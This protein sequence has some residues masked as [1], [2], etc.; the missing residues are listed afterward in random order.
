MSRKFAH[1]VKFDSSSDL[2]ESLIKSEKHNLK[3]GVVVK[4][5][6]TKIE[7]DTIVVDIGYKTE[8]RIPA[9]EFKLIIGAVIPN[10]GDTV[11]VYIERLEGRGGK[12]IL[13]RQKA[14]REEAWKCLEDSYAKG[15][16][17]DGVIFSRVKGG[18]AVDLSGVVG[19]LPGGQVDIRPIKDPTPLMNIVQ[20]FRILKMDSVQGNIVIS[21]RAVIED[22]RAEEKEK[23]LSTVQEGMILDGFV[24]NITDYG[25]FIDL[26]SVDGL[27]HITDIS[28]KRINHPSEEL[29]LGQSIKVMVT[30]FD[31]NTKRIH[32]G[33][34]QLSKSPWEHIDSKYKTG[35]RINGKVVNLTDY[36]AFVELEEG[37]EG[38]LHSSEIS[39][40]KVD[41]SPKKLFTIGQEIECTIF[42]LEK[43]NNK[44]FLS[45]KRLSPNPWHLFAETNQVGGVIKCQVRN[46][47]SYAL[48]VAIGDQIDGMIHESDLSW[49]G[50]GLEL[51]KKY[52]KGDTVECKILAIDIEKEKVALGIKQLSDDPHKESYSQLSIG[53]VVSATIKSLD[54]DY[55]VQL[56]VNN[57]LPAII[58]KSEF[59]Y[60]RDD[61]NLPK[62]GEV[63]KA[64]I[65]QV[66]RGAHLIILSIREYESDQREK[67]IKEYSSANTDVHSIGSILSDNASK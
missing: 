7:S 3:E 39:W 25:A 24:K 36:A 56:T 19:F 40:G 32:L 45:I 33:L 41:G 2:F 61:R 1:T 54:H 51:I 6:V 27:L 34:K 57:G 47:V 30:K 13:S 48:F 64:K 60:N 26:G 17:V 59:G 38:I 52:S 65:V 50:N 5:I 22:S 12:T 67:V 63:I 31:P 18:L 44:M 66:D 14:I 53:D 46:I 42:N 8:G 23:M 15:D 16:L 43:D 28:W 55:N 49:E 21:R 29:Q 62:V 4:G 35:D 11:D 9:D 20:K 10:V 58:K 37:I